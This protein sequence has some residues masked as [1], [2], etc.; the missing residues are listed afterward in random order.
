VYRFSALPQGRYVIALPSVQPRGATETGVPTV[1]YPFASSIAAATVLTLRAGET[2]ERI[3]L[4]AEARPGVRLSGSLTGLDQRGAQGGGANS[5]AS[6]T[7]HLMPADAPGTPADCDAL[8]AVNGHDGHFMFSNVPP[9]RYLIR[10][11]DVPA[12]RAE[13]Q[14]WTGGNLTMLPLGQRAPPRSAP[15]QATLWVEESVVVGTKDVENVTVP[16]HV[17]RRISGRFAFEGGPITSSMLS[18]VVSVRPADGRDFGASMPVTRGDASGAFQT[19][20]LPAGPYRLLPLIDA[21]GWVVRSV[22]VGGRDLGADPIVLG[23]ADIGDVMIT[24]SAQNASVSGVVRAASGATA[25]DASV[26]VFSTDTGAWTEPVWSVPQVIH[27]ARGDERGAY[28]VDGLVPGEYFVAVVAKGEPETWRAPAFLAAMAKTAMKVTI[29]DRE[30][31][32]IN[33]AVRSPR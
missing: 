31:R 16:V 2:R 21:P 13:T 11:I 17:G 3:D 5:T 6:L 8:H 7:L 23:A 33:L 30:Q 14:S 12:G 20:G 29:G 27:E 24:V 28:R 19:I 22:L 9:G 26:Y 1:Y 4:R 15:A 32:I 10:G 25:A 18:S